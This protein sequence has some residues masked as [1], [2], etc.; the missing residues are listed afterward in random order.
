MSFNL[1]NNEKFGEP[2]SPQI[3]LNLTLYPQ[4]YYQCYVYYW[5]FSISTTLLA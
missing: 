4:L 1:K 2:I 5:G 3:E